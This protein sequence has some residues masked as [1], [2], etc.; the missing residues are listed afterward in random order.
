MITLLTG[1]RL[2]SALDPGSAFDFAE[3]SISLSLRLCS[4]LDLGKTEAVLTVG[5]VFDG[6]KD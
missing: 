3:P 2:R 1:L 5:E 6:L 4:A